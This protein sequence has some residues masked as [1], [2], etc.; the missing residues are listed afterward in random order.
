MENNQTKQCSKCKEIKE[1][2]EFNTEKRNKDGFTGKCTL[3]IS[4]HRKE[5]RALNKEAI[6]LSKKKYYIENKSKI[7]LGAK[8]IYENDKEKIKTRIQKWRDENKEHVANYL[9]AYKN[10]Y[11]KHYKNTEKYTDSRKRCNARR[12]K[13]IFDSSDGSLTIDYI[14]SLKDIQNDKCY[15]CDNPLDFKKKRS[16]HMDH[17]MPISKGGK[18]SV[19][20]VVLSCAKCNISKGNSIPKTPLVFK[21]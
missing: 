3:C 10:E 9:K 4:V 6:S 15:Y 8:K 12:A 20:N 1:L 7:I 14:A 13:R 18:H 21:I 5:F 11:L 2:T 17:Y 16:V 19:G